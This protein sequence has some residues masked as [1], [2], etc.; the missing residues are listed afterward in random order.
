MAR[1]ITILAALALVFRPS[2]QEELAFHS[3]DAEVAIPK[4]RGY[5]ALRAPRVIKGKQDFKMWEYD[6]GQQCDLSKEYDRSAATFVL[7]DG[8][9]ISNVIFGTRQITCVF[10][11]GS[12]TLTNV[13]F[14]G[15]CDGEHADSHCFSQMPTK[16]AS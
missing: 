10:C 15:L 6:R 11:L 12:C 13:W 1:L 14:R 2:T 16:F 5:T 7:E 9:S 8:A 3:A 4:A